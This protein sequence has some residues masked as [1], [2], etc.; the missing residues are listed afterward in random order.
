M[1][2]GR[3]PLTANQ[4][5]AYNLMRARKSQGWSQDQAAESLEPYL[6]V[7]WSKTVYS[8]AERSYQSKRVR[9]FTADEILAMSRAFGVPP[10]YFFLPPPADARDGASGVTSGG[11]EIGWHDLLIVMFNDPSLWTVPRL[12]DLPPGEVEPGILEAQAA[13]P[14]RREM[15][16]RI[17]DL[18]RR[19]QEARNGHTETEG[20][21]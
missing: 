10:L 8:A 17:E 13:V 2:T 5:V 7:R 20:E 18:E 15:V 6:G 11:R 3:M 1:Q 12:R 16:E 9:Q 4:L 19:L 14:W 21:D